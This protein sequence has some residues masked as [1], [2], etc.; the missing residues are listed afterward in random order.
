MCL[1]TTR[2]DNDELLRY[3]EMKEVEDATRRVT[4]RVYYACAMGRLEGS[5]V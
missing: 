3:L 1:L 2:K 5:E 4:E